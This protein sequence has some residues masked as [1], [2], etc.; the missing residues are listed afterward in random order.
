MKKITLL[1]ATIILTSC[2]ARKSEV[3]KEDTKTEIKTE[4]VTKIDAVTETTVTDNTITDTQ[5][6]NIEPVDNNKPIEVTKPDGSKITIYNG[7][8]QSKTKKEVADKK[9]ITKE[10]VQ[11]VKETKADVKQETSSKEKNTDRKAYNGWMWWLLLL[12][13]LAIVARYIY[14]RYTAS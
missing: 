14:K 9:E 1:L 6:W 3:K 11:A 7:R 2:G 4:E 12:I 8:I 10:V 13:P 5:E